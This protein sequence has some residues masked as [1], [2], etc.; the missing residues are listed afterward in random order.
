MEDDLLFTPEE[1]STLNEEQKNFLRPIRM[2]NLSAPGQAEPSGPVEKQKFRTLAQGLSFGFSDEIEAV[3][4]SAIPGGPNYTELR[5]QLRQKVSDYQQAYPGEAI[6]MEVIGGL[7]TGLVPF[8]GQARAASTMGR[9]IGTSA[10]EGALYGLGTS[11]ADLFGEGADPLQA[12]L[13]VA[14]G[15]VTGAGTTT[16]ATTAFR[17]IGGVGSKFVNYVREKFG[18]RYSDDVQAYIGGLA[19]QSGKSVDEIVADIAEGRAFTDNAS[20]NAALKQFILEGGKP[21]QELLEFVQNRAQTLRGQARSGLQ[22]SLAPGTGDN[23][24]DEFMTRTERLRGQESSQ[25]TQIFA[26]HP[27]VTRPIANQVERLLQR[28]PTVRNELGSLYQERNLVPL[29]KTTD[30]GAVELARAPSLEDAD[31]IYRLLRDEGQQ[32]SISGRGTRSGVY[33]TDAN[34]LKTLLD[35]TYTDLRDARANYSASFS[36][37][38]AFD[39]GLA[40]L[41]KN[42]DMTARTFRGMNADQQASFRIGVFAAL[43]D[44]LR[45]T[46]QST[47]AKLAEED[48]QLGDLLRLVAPTE[49]I[50]DLA[51][52]L[53]IAAEAGRTSAYLPQRAGSQTLP[54]MM[55]RDKGIPVTAQDLTG[56]ASGDPAA[57][58]NIAN[59]TVRALTQAT[60][61]SEQGRQAVVDI[62]TS[63]DPNIWIKALTDNSQFDQLSALINRY[64]A[65]VAPG[66]R[67]ALTQ[68]SA[69]GMQGL[70][71]M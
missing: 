9:L 44:K 53:G 34:N 39:E 68:Q 14:V 60:P 37:S 28:Y 61:L 7:A 45:R 8:A 65:A 18:T 13:D 56:A 55:A 2:Q 64:A 3:I 22:E 59:K 48:Q 25:Y 58:A 54:L 17:A 20:V 47:I 71:G 41:N 31:N 21:A 42:V 10:A 43:R 66:A 52:T 12:G 29:F 49:S 23:V 4:R 24:L 50:D 27:S 63:Q 19:S 57:M 35:D 32:L 11:E 46:P 30:D 36:S 33:K 1:L 69:S 16:A 15:G 38:E 51:R 62:L 26:N 6:T 5:D 67:T 40:S 70:L